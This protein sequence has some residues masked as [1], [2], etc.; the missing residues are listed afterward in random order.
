MHLPIDSLAGAATPLLAQQAETTPSFVK[1]GVA[2]LMILIG[3]ILIMV[4][5]NNIQTQE[6]EETGARRLIM[7][8]TGSEPTHRGNMA[9]LIGWGRI[10]GGAILILAGIGFG[11]FGPILAN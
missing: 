7:Q 5:R 4:G 11:I 3:L 10:I 9:V 6:A 8:A 2:A 1:F